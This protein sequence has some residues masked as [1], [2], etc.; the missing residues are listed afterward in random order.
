V[1]GANPLHPLADV[2]RAA[3]RLRHFLEQAL[4]EEMAEGVDMAHEAILPMTMLS[5]L[6]GL[7]RQS[8]ASS[9]EDGC[10]GQARA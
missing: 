3:G 10:A 1:D 2:L 7:T 5:S 9:Q 4:R 6:P 8:I